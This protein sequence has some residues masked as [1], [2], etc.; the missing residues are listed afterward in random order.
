MANTA[1]TFSRIDANGAADVTLALD[2]LRR[3]IDEALSA[4]LEIAG[5]YDLSSSLP[6]PHV[7][8]GVLHV[9]S[10]AL[11]IVL[12]NGR[13]ISLARRG[14]ARRL[15]QALVSQHQ[16]EKG[17]ALSIHDAFEAGWPNERAQPD[18]AAARVY[19]TIRILRNLGLRPWLLGR[20]DGYLL[21]P[22]LVIHA[23]SELNALPELGA[24]E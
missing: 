2:R 19:T 21:A 14:P 17:H 23:E 22:D 10:Q 9:A 16:R 6:P 24:A 18:A 3:A 8:S 4:M 1:R 12:P 5:S 7:A 15:F 11:E 20:D 13:S